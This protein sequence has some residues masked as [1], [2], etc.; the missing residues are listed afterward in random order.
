[1]K[2]IISLLLMLLPLFGSAQVL[3][4]EAL[5]DKVIST[6]KTDLPL[7][8]EYSYVVYD[9]DE[10]IDRDKGVMKLEGCRYSLLMNK[11]AV[12]CNGETQWSYMH[13]VNEIYISDAS[14]DEAQ[15][16]SPL[17]IME[18]YR[19]ECAKK[20]ELQNGDLVITLQAMSDSDV[21]KVV[22]FIDAN[23]NRLKS[24]DVLISGQGNLKIVLDKYQVKC[25]FAS[26]VYECPVKDYSTAEIID[27]R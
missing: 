22:L 18:N 21:E 10:E 9:G 23:R 15:N 8:M 24:L 19:N 6:M 20:A 27:M 13:E 16:L 17:F 1:M 25:N 11:M 12:W 2:N 3:N 14:S 4:A 7:Q 5:L 26:N